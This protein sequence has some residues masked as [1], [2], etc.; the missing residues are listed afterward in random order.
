M[1]FLRRFYR[2]EDGNII[3]ISI[4][5]FFAFI[6]LAGLVVDGGHL[7]LTKAHLQKTANAAVLSGGQE[8]AA[9]SLQK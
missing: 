7:Y 6:A 4:F 8:L 9:D 5:L 3:F 1:M 2:N